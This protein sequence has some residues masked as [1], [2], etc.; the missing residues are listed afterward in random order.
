MGK[1]FQILLGI[2]AK[3][4]STSIHWHGLRQYHTNIQDGANGVTECPLAPGQTKTHT[5]RA[6]QHGKSEK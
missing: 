5:F 2:C 3:Q 4:Y 6:T 1:A